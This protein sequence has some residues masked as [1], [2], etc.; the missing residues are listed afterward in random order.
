MSALNQGNQRGDTRHFAVSVTDQFIG[1]GTTG[2]MASKADRLEAIA[3]G[4]GM[5]PN[6][7]PTVESTTRIYGD[8]AVTIRLNRG[9][10]GENRQTTVHVK[11]GGKGC[12]R[13]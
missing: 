11:Q 3:A 4:Q 10:D 1:I 13:A 9:A 8:L 6:P 12:G 2:S 5:P 7:A